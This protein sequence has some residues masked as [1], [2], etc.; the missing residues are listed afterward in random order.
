MVLDDLQWADSASM[1]LLQALLSDHGNSRLVV[2]G[3]YRDD[4]NY[5]EMSH[6]NSIAA[7]YDD[8]SADP[9]LQ[10]DAVSIG[11]LD[12]DQVND[13]LDDLLT[14][15]SGATHELAECI[16]NKTLGNIFFVI[17]FLT[18]LQE[19]ELL[20]FNFGAMRWV[21]EEEKIKRETAATE[22]VAGLICSKKK[23][24]PVSIGRVL[25]IMVCLGSSLSSHHFH[26]VVRVL[27]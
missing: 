25:P 1:D 27:Q 8:A 17:Q 18:F 13:L 5:K 24:F 3:C 19:S 2:I 11:N 23:A 26:V 12:T 15:H 20:T 21:Y 4:D 7:I 16:H 14:S 9:T 22:N 10:V 6:L